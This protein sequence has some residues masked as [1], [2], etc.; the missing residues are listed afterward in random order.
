M[1]LTAHIAD[2]GS[3]IG[4][5]LWRRYGHSA[6]LAH[7]ANHQL[8]LATTLRPDAESYPWPTV[9][10][11]VD[12]RIQCSFAST[13]EELR[14]SLASPARGARI[15][16]STH[17]TQY[18][19]AVLHAFFDQF[20]GTLDLLQP[21]GRPL[22]DDEEA[23]LARY[24]YVLATL[25]EVAR[26]R[27]YGDG[28]LFVPSP[29]PDVASLLEIASPAVVDDLRQLGQRFTDGWLS[30]TQQ[31]HAL[32]PVFS[33]GA[34][35]GGADVDLLVDHCAILL[36]T[37]AQPHI[38]SRWLRQLMAT[39]LLDTHDAYH[40]HSAGIYMARQGVLL[41][42]SLDDLSATLTGQPGLSLARQRH[43]FRRICQLAKG[44]EA[45]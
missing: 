20:S 35:L 37:T 2:N 1:S 15:L 39:V 31:P 33:G 14:A 40:L 34:V 25:E 30:L 38:E 10:R 4:H 17:A 3:L 11:A 9:S 36:K 44:Q 18:P 19:A 16:A 24:C 12:Y 42:W 41:R 29:R 8:G 28:P 21:A 27:W 43:E 5:Y 45:A 6:P 23:V 32:N 26:T 7:V 22:G 13:R